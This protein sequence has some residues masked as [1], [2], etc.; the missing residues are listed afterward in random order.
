MSK[1]VCF[2]LILLFYLQSVNARVFIGFNTGFISGFI[3][4]SAAGNSH[5]SILIGSKMEHLAL[6]F[7]FDLEHWQYKTKYKYK[8]TENTDRELIVTATPT[9][10]FKYYFVKNKYSPILNI[11][12][13]K[14]CPIITKYEKSD[15]DDEEYVKRVEKLLRDRNDDFCGNIAL[16]IEYA[17]G[18]RFSIIGEYGINVFLL[19]YETRNYTDEYILILTKASLTF[20]YYFK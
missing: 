9:I 16:G 19:N 15:N 17:L 7:G 12:L 5:P 6:Y 11:N 20:L 13:S 10:G 1:K 4:S 3:L 18:D 2:L 8:D 14:E